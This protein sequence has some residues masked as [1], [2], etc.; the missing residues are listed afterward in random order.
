M[1]GRRLIALT[2]LLYPLFVFSDNLPPPGPP[3]CPPGLCGG[4][5]ITGQTIASNNASSTVAGA[6]NIVTLSFSS[7]QS[8]A[9]TPIVTIAGHS[10]SATSSDGLSWSASVSMLPGDLEGVVAFSA[11]VSNTAGTGSTIFSSTSDGSLVYFDATPPVITLTGTSSVT[12]TV[13]DTY[14]D[15]GA[16]ALDLRDGTLSV[17]TS[18]S[19]DTST[20]GTY[21]L[22]YDAA[23]VAG[24]A[25]TPVIRTVTVNAAPI[26]PPA[27]PEP[28]PTPVPA[29]GG[30]NGPVVGS[31]GEV[32]YTPPEQPLPEGPVVETPPPPN[33]TEVIEE[34]V[35]LV[36]PSP[37][38]PKI[39]AAKNVK[40]IIPRAP[41]QVATVL[42]AVD[43]GTPGWLLWLL[44]LMLLLFNAAWIWY[45]PKQQ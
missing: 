23:D 26:P 13:G 34:A 18:G 27:P 35:T 41:A 14:A 38:K 6:S 3:P 15:A 7:D 9:T 25:A 33:D 10:A 36:A 31:Y 1:R 39:V 28:V 43:G 8:A 42:R 2:L 24:N 29:G 21:T 32:N 20:A 19:V 45:T 11:S 22:T 5:L 40:K 30:G 44:L 4:P 16:T 12:L 17:S 37:V